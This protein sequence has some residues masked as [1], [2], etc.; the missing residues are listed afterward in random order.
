VIAEAIAAPPDA[1]EATVLCVVGEE[2]SSEA[3]GVCLL[4]CEVAVLFRSDAE[5]AAMIGIPASTVTHTLHST[6]HA[7]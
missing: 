5:E 2:I 3:T 4:S 1:E 7:G 6:Q